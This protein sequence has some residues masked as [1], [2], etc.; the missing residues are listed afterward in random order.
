MGDSY[1]SIFGVRVGCARRACVRRRER[2]GGGGVMAHGIVLSYNIYCCVLRLTE[3]IPTYCT[4]QSLEHG[5]RTGVERS[6][7]VV[8]VPEAAKCCR[9]FSCEY[10][11]TTLGFAFLEPC[12]RLRPP[13]F[14]CSLVNTALFVCCVHTHS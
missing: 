7:L 4:F 12:S 1:A 2:G 10:G 8:K 3:V 13:P 5:R 14:L 9:H 6:T 11:Q